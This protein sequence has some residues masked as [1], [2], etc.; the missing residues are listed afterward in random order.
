MLGLLRRFIGRMVSLLDSFPDLQRRSLVRNYIKGRGIEIGA[1]HRPLRV[2]SQARVTYVDRLWVP[3]L[4]QRYP[5]LASR[6]LAKV[7]V[8]DDIERLTRI[9]DASQDFLIANHVLE[10]CQNPIGALLNFL[11]VLRGGGV[12]YL[13]VQDDRYT[14]NGTRPVTSLEHLLQDLERGPEWSKQQHLEEWTRMVNG[15]QE[16]DEVAEQVSTL[17]KIDYRIQY[18][19][20]TQLEL[21]QM[22]LLVRKKLS[23]EIEVFLKRNKEVLMILR[24]SE[25]TAMPQVNPAA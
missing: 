22:L 2:S 5:E 4:Q 24:R 9:Q 13:A 1:L 14:L 11:R 17:M 16:A 21:L 23:F 25:P 10:H 8:V 12:L 3:G 6:K 19:V 18:H 20:W 15:V 7:G